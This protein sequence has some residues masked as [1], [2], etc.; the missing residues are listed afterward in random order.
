MVRP[1]QNVGAPAKP[2]ALVSEPLKAAGRRQDQS[3]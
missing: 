1:E 2:G 3:N